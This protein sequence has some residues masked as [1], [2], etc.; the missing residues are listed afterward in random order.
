MSTSVESNATPRQQ[1]VWD[2]AQHDGTDYLQRVARTLHLRGFDAQMLETLEPRFEL[3]SFGES[4]SRR[5]LL[6]ADRDARLWLVLADPF[7][8]LLRQWAMNRVKKPFAFAFCVPAE[9]TAY[10]ALHES[11]HQA[12]TQIDV[13]GQ[14]AATADAGVE[15]TLATLAADVHPVIRLVNSRC[16]TR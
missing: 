9:L 11:A 6:G 3:L 10:L 14:F 5:C 4:L 15:I 7:D 8:P 12:L 1:Q 2:D 16:T 13:G